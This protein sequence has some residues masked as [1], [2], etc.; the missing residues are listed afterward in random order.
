VTPLTDGKGLAAIKPTISQG[1]A[2]FPATAGSAAELIDRA[3][4]ALYRAKS[5][6]RDQIALDGSADPS[7]ALATGGA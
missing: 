4:A 3:H 2:A 1:I 7:C 6:G 5:R